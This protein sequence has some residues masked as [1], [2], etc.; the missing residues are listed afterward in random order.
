MLPD[1][2][3]VRPATPTRSVELSALL[4][5]A[6]FTVIDFFS[7]NC[8]C[9]RAHD[10]RL[11]AL[12]RR[13]GPA[14]VQVIAVDPEVGVT[15]AELATEARQ[16]RYA[17]P[18]LGDPDARLAR[19]AGAEFATYVLL[20]DRHGRIHYR[21]GIDSDHTRLTSDRVPY[22]ENAIRDVLAGRQPRRAQAKTLGC[23]LRTY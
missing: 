13:Y 12:S 4:A 11:K 16:R 22:L 20:V 6:R 5:R 19:A 8:A 3:L 17:F 15:P 21:G 18:L 2:T 10:E 9:Q 1:A 14:G 7:A 23:A